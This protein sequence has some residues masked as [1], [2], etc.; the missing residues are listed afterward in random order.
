[1]SCLRCQIYASPVKQVSL[2]IY[3]A[4]ATQF[5]LMISESAA[6]VCAVESTCQP[7]SSFIDDFY[8]GNESVLVDDF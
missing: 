1:M 4:V 6:I 3:E 8:I 2:M 5:S 7:G